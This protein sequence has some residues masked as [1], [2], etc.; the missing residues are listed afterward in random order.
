VGGSL[1]SLA[2]LRERTQVNFH[3]RV[4]S[5][6]Q[7]LDASAE[8]ASKWLAANL[9]TRSS[10]KHPKSRTN[11]RPWSI[12]SSLAVGWCWSA[13]L[14]GTYCATRIACQHHLSVIGHRR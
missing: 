1:L 13:F 4:Y 9:V 11:A 10:R 5:E 12:A 2:I 6:A 14:D 7:E 8:V 3:G